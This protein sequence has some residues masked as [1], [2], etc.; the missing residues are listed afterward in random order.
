MRAVLSSIF[1]LVFVASAQTPW[2]SRQNRS[3]TSDAVDLPSKLTDANKL[4]EF[5]VYGGA[6]FTIPSI[7][8]NGLVLI[9]GN[10]KALTQKEF[11]KLDRKQGG[12][13]L[14]CLDVKTGDVK[15]ELL[16]QGVGTYNSYGTYG[17]CSTP[18]IEDDR[19]YVISPA[20]QLVCIDM[21]GQANGNDGP[22]TDELA[23]MS[24]IGGPLVKGGKVEGEPL[25]ELKPSFGDII[26]VYEFFETHQ[27]AMKHCHSGTPLIDGNVIYLPTSNSHHSIAKYKGKIY[28][29]YGRPKDLPKE[30][31]YGK[32][33]PDLVAIDKRTGKLLAR[34]KLPRHG[35]LHGQWSTPCMGT[36]SGRKLLFYATGD[37]VIHAFETITANDVGE[38]VKILK[39]V[40]RFD[41]VPTE[42]RKA[43]DGPVSN[44]R[45][46]SAKRSDTIFQANIM[47]T[48]VFANGKLYASLSRDPARPIC[49]GILYCIDPAGAGDI[50]KT[51]VIWKVD[52]V[53]TSL[54]GVAVKDGLVYFIDSGG[55]MNCFDEASGERIWQQHLEQ[56]SFYCDPLLADGKLFVTTEKEHWILETGR[57]FKKLERMRVRGGECRMPAATN[58]I[59]LIPTNKRLYAYSGTAQKQTENEEQAEAE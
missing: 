43:K 44:Y 56:D 3:G 7:S 25:T 41:A 59:L 55:V 49:R 57:E 27:I 17:M 23:Y 47:G 48:L 22:F 1:I 28:D 21:K 18:I 38:E 11:G 34:D 30:H 5:N 26:W 36:V 40:W 24:N 37:G 54:A 9:G 31:T 35:V 53:L 58:G 15:W 2:S 50:T 12:G 19:A 52:D 39:E 46:S 10:Q 6:Q 29:A 13:G 51:N 45:R 32:Y 20:G 8:K 33:G 42:Y 4:W 16:L 14:I